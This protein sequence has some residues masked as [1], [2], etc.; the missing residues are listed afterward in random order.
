MDNFSGMFIRLTVVPVSFV[1]NSQL[2]NESFTLGLDA[3]IHALRWNS[4]RNTLQDKTNQQLFLE[5][6]DGVLLV[7]IKESF[8]SSSNIS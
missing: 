6:N 8:T 7:V 2:C 3:T 4:S 1:I 5:G